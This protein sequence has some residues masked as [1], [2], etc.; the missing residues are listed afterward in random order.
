KIA[1]QT[2]LQSLQAA[3]GVVRCPADGR[4]GQAGV[5]PLA[6]HRVDAIECQPLAEEVGALRPQVADLQDGVPRDLLLYGEAPLIDRDVL[7]VAVLPRVG[8]VERRGAEERRERI[9][10]AWTVLLRQTEVLPDVGVRGVQPAEL[11]VAIVDAAAHAN[12]GL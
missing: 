2:D 3:I 7:A 5:R 12:S 9:R 10:E 8:D 1:A 11:T 6:G 4:A